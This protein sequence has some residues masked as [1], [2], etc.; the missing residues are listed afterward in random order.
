MIENKPNPLLVPK[1]V[2]TNVNIE[3]NP[4]C[5]AYDAPHLEKDFPYISLVEKPKQEVAN[6]C[7]RNMELSSV[8][9]S[10]LVLYSFVEVTCLLSCSPL[11][12]GGTSSI[13]V[14]LSLGLM[15]ISCP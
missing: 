15:Q 5:L 8:D 11:F 4:C 10:H 14:L 1:G 9:R 13:F 12:F 2:M 7:S 3:A 6:V